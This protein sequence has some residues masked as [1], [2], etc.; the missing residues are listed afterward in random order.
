MKKLLF[1]LMGVSAM[2]TALFAQDLSVCVSKG[3][4]LT[5]TADAVGV[6]PITYQWYENG[7]K[8]GT[9]QATL[10]IVGGRTAGEYAYV[11]VASNAACTLSSNTYTVRVKPK[12]IISRS[13]GDA[14]QT[15][16][17][18]P[19]I[20]TIIYT[21]SDDAIISLSAGSFPKGVTG[22]PNGSSFTISGTPTE[23]GTFGYALTASNGCTGAAVAGTITITAVPTTLC[24]QC[25]Y[26]GAA[27]VDCYVTTNAYPFDNDNTNT[28]AV[29][30]GNSTT[31]YA[32]ASGSGSDKNGRVNT[33][34]ISSSTV[35]V[36][37][38]QICKNLG[39]GW[40]LPAYEELYAMSN[41]AA[42]A[43]S[44]NLAGKNLLASPIG[45][46]WSSTEYYG[47]GGRNSTSDTNYQYRAASAYSTGTLSYTSKVNTF[48]VRC[49][50]RP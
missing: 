28:T 22:A 3:Y 44:N 17:Q 21:A 23:S 11:R 18:G 47:N 27:W 42:N 25:C 4:T 16:P 20:T 41:G 13:G 37:A 5:S 48:Y 32:G 8:V 39:T 46:Y 31:F 29:W 15:V 38:V 9:G 40:Y 45:N 34:N 50:W 6:V 14:S 10:G 36:N 24:T 12:P 19:P 35:T 33:A 7:A 30:S 1:T 26:H 43:N 2:T 49:A